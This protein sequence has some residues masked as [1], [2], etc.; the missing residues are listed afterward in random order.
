MAVLVEAG[1]AVNARFRGAHAET[2]LH[3]AASNDDVEVLDALLDA[4]ADIE[5]PGAVLGGGSPLADAC[6]FK[7]WAA[8]HRLVERGAHA[9]LFDAATLGLT[10]RVRSWCESEPP[11]SAEDVT[12]AFWGACHGGRR[13]CA[14]YLLER[15]ADLNWIPPWEP[16]SPLE[17]AERDGAADLADRLRDL[18]ARRA[19]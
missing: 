2:P 19:S 6:G 14:E 9:S 13:D 11:P 16:A 4:G 10:D 1:A 3:W 5:A 17:A 18:G 12:E 15:G 8:A 7:Q